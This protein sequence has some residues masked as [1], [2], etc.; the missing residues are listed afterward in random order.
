MP[1]VVFYFECVRNFI[2]PSDTAALQN[3][4]MNLSDRAGAYF[5]SAAP[6]NE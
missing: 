2:K 1:T 5:G 3:I 6:K 4:N